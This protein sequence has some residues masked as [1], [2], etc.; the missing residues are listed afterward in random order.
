MIEKRKTNEEF[1]SELMA[2][3]QHG[4]LAQIFIIE[5]IRYYAEKVSNS[6]AENDDKAMINPTAWHAVA[7]EILEK[8]RLNYE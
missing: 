3:N 8:M 7:T 4:G 6:E 2:Y 1:V 5:A